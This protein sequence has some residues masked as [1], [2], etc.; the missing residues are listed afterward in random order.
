MTDRLF[1][2]DAPQESET[3][4]IS[5]IR[6]R[7]KVPVDGC[8]FFAVE[9]YNVEVKTV[10]DDTDVILVPV[11][12]YEH[13]RRFLWRHCLFM[14]V[15]R[16]AGSLKLAN[17]LQTMLKRYIMYM[18]GITEGL[19]QLT[20]FKKGED[21][22]LRSVVFDLYLVTEFFVGRHEY[23]IGDAWR[24]Q[25]ADTILERQSAAALDWNAYYHACDQRDSVWSGSKFSFSI[26][27]VRGEAPWQSLADAAATYL[28]MENPKVKSR[29]RKRGM[30]FGSKKKSAPRLDTEEEE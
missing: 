13:V 6:Y 21:K 24:C 11:H 17:G 26:G 1:P 18:D 25:N 16:R 19:L 5:A 7:A 15:W 9:I 3:R 2:N 10:T 4:S 14:E 20:D 27:K 29:K 23:D 12:Y 30:G 8:D 28:G 22:D